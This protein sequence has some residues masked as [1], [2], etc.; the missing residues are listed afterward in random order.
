MTESTRPTLRIISGTP[1]ADELAVLTALV[2]AASGS[3]SSDDPRAQRGNWNDRS[4]LIRHQLMPGP[5]AWRS[6]YR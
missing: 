2:S 5:N 3:D 1:T 6:S 4:M